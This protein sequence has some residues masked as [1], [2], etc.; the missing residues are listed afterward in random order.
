MGRWEDLR[1]SCGLF[2]DDAILVLNK[3]AGISVVG[4]RHSDDLLSLAKDAGELVY[5]VHRIDKV[6]SGA[7]LLAKDLKTHGELTRQFAK[8]NVEKSYLAITPTVGMPSS[9]T[10]DLPLYTASSGRVRIAGNRSDIV[11]DAAQQSWRIPDDRVPAKP[12]HFPS[13]TDFVKVFE[14]DT[15]TLLLLRPFT[16]RRHQIRVHL[17]WVGHPISGDPLF[18]KKAS[19][20]GNRTALHSLQLSFDT[21]WMP[22]PRM[23]IEAVPTADFWAPFSGELPTDIID[24]VHACDVE[25][26]RINSL[27]R[28]AVSEHRDQSKA[29]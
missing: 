23:E 22:Q 21:D 17:A 8:R 19:S 24:R 26:E 1:N 18:D 9:A 20:S 13:R 6:T 16:G 5:A 14:S 27:H 29:R 11:F 7:V 10:L 2:E 15:H 4:E 12:R 25:I 3:P 28:G